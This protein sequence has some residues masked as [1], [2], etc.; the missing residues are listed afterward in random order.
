VRERGDETLLKVHWQNKGEKKRD[1]YDGWDEWMGL[2]LV[3]DG[4]MGNERCSELKII[5]I[6]DVFLIVIRG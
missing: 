1:G 3:D 6:W 2:G 4:W 5:E